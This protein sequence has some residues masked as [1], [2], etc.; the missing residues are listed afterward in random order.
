M[1]RPCVEVVNR[2]IDV[3]GL[4]K[5]VE[6]DRYG[7][8]C[9]FVGR[10]RNHSQGEP[11]ARLEYR[12]YEEM[13]GREMLKV[14]AEAAERW[15]CNVAIEH[16]LGVIEVGEASIA[17]AVASP[18]RA[19]AFEACRYCIDTIKQ[20]VPIWKREERPDGTFWIE[21]DAPVRSGTS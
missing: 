4:E 3:A 18:H 20:R 9:T 1:S 5:R 8:I 14:A 7:A 19:E 17:I 21:G 11:V 2:P 15:D 10:V 6:R 16:R 12:A 13:A